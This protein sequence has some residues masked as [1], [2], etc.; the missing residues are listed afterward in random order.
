M[1]RIH[2][3]LPDLLQD[4]VLAVGQTGLICSADGWGEQSVEG[5]LIDFD[6]ASRVVKI[7]PAGQLRSLSLKFNQIK[8]LK[9][10]AHPDRAAAH[11]RADEHSLEL[12]P[13]THSF[14]VSL[15]DGA[16]YLNP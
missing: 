3:E 15:R 5:Q 11:G 1:S 7:R 12:L 16:L 8:R 6:P 2:F 4:E 14:L 10:D 9:I 13:S